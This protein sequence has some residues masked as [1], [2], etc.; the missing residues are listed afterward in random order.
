M[1]FVSGST[2]NGDSRAE[3]DGTGTG[4]CGVSGNGGTANVA[5]FGL[6]DW[7][8]RRLAPLTNK[9]WIRGLG[10][11]CGVEMR[12]FIEGRD[13]QRQSPPGKEQVSDEQDLGS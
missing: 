13:T 1:T 9:G 5:A 10:T 3:D 6:L 12:G 2:A 8:Y 11:R 7:T 4:V